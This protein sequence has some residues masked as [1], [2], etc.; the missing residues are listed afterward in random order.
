M[1]EKKFKIGP[2]FIWKGAGLILA[3]LTYIVSS[4][5]DSHNQKEMKEE[6]KNELREELSNDQS[7]GTI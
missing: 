3:G 5:I 4:V 2:S 6:I 7:Q 1:K